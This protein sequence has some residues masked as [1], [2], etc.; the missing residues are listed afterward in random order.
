MTSN[1]KDMYAVFGDG[2]V[3]LKFIIL[4]V[5]VIQRARSYCIES[6]Y[7]VGLGNSLL[8]QI[9]ADVFFWRF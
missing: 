9:M 7:N 4:L 3:H 8:I 1:N 6:G 2:E 5:K